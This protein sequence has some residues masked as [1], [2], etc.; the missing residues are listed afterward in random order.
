MRN[1]L[2]RVP[3]LV[4]SRIL[5]YK[6]CFSTK[7]GAQFP[8]LTPPHLTVTLPS[9]AHSVCSCRLSAGDCKLPMSLRTGT[10][11]RESEQRHA[12]KFKASNK[13]HTHTH[14]LWR[15]QLVC[16][17]RVWRNMS[18]WNEYK[19]TPSSLCRGEGEGEGEE[20]S[21]YRLTSLVLMTSHT[22][23]N[24]KGCISIARAQ[25]YLVQQPEHTQ[26]PSNEVVCVCEKVRKQQAVTGLK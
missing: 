1:V 3:T 15:Q 24:I 2:D 21:P 16:T 18:C 14:S 9:V 8:N 13:T 6:Q 5:S 7:E 20:G 26:N 19:W 17:C 10:P 22:S 12:Y 23:Q 25:I 4:S 11:V